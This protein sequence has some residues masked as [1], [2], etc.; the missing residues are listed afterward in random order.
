MPLPV[1]PPAILRVDSLPEAVVGSFSRMPR[2]WAI[3]RD[4]SIPSRSTSAWGRR[5]EASSRTP[6]AFGSYRSRLVLELASPEAHT[7]PTPSPR[8]AAADEVGDGVIGSLWLQVAVMVVCLLLGAAVAD[9]LLRFVCQPRIS[10]RDRLLEVRLAGT[11]LLGR[12]PL[13]DIE[14][15]RRLSGR[16]AMMDWRMWFGCLRFGLVGLGSSGAVL[17]LLHHA[18]SW[19]FPP[20]PFKYRRLMFFPRDSRAFVSYLTAPPQV[21]D[22][23]PNT[24]RIGPIRPT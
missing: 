8:S 12:I 17:V 9:G 16:E 15:V 23:R 1:R 7:R 13:S 14:S 5:S 11:L 21:K 20:T 6:T 19:R 22:R 4:H 10:D 18:I 2:N 3:S 24:D